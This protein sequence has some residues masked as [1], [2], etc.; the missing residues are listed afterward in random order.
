MTTTRSQSRAQ[1]PAANKKFFYKS[2][3]GKVIKELNINK[4]N[5]FKEKKQMF[6]LIKNVD[7]T[8]YEKNN[9]G[10]YKE[11]V[12]NIVFKNVQELK[13]KYNGKPVI[14]HSFIV[15]KPA[16]SE[17]IEKFISNYIKDI[18]NIGLYYISSN[19]EGIGWRSSKKLEPNGKVR[20]FN[21]DDFEIYNDNNDIDFNQ[22]IIDF[23]LYILQK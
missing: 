6:Y 14:K 23:N 12:E 10:L 13:L 22:E 1:A 18:H 3:N 17:E 15:K 8:K 11:K 21:P 4:G 16:G 20:I 19:F 9:D 5:A 2:K 7:M